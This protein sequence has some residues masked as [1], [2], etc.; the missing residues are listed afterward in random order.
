VERDAE[1]PLLRRT[2]IARERPLRAL[3]R[4][5]AKAPGRQCTNTVVFDDYTEFDR[6][7]LNVRKLKRFA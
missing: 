3:I 1:N 7:S 5:M 6:C 4:V 2:R